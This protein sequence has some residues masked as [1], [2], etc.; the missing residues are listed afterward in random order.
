M[1]ISVLASG[2]KGNCVYIEG[3]SGALLIDAGRSA[4]DI[5]GTRDRGGR[6]R[7]A[8]G[9]P[10]LIDGILVT[11][12]HTDHIRGLG[13]IG[14]KL[15]KSAFGT[16]GTMDAFLRKQSGPPRFPIK[17]V[18][19]GFPFDVGGFQVEAFPISHD[20]TEP[21]GYL[22]SE[23]STRLCYCTDTGI[24]TSGMQEMLN[25]ADGLIIESNHCTE[26]LRAGPYPEYLKRRIASH[27]GHLS[28]TDASAVLRELGDSLHLAIL[29]HLS[30]ENNEPDLALITAQEGL[31]L[32]AESVEL[33]AASSIGLN[34]K[35]PVRK[36]RGIRRQ[37]CTDECWQYQ[38][39]L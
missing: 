3:D 34:E 2:S 15:K 22:I 30:E 17:T 23:G 32:H 7:E 37:T 9:D 28:N 39:V 10:E 19:C 21:C 38:F 16:V 13:P 11:H 20:A 12:E 35:P 8:G 6:V 4:R 33:F 36:S 29:A 5:F 31:S 25:Q 24:V 14:N 1:R 27:R 18:R 26:M